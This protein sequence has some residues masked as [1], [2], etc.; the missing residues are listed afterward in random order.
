MAA[1]LGGGVEQNKLLKKKIL[2]TLTS[3][4]IMCVE[5]KVHVILRRYIVLAWIHDTRESVQ[6]VTLWNNT[7]VNIAMMTTRCVRVC[8]LK[9]LV[10]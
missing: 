6:H 3:P 5:T 8:G 10:D 7:K 4:G 1:N 2:Y 9:T